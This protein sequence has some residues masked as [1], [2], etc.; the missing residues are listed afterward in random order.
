MEGGVKGFFIG[1]DAISEPKAQNLKT[2]VN[3]SRK[4]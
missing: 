4:I 3:I 2:K 1:T